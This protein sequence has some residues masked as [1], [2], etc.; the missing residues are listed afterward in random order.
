MTARGA[1]ALGALG[2]IAAITVAWWSLALWPLAALPGWL[3]R[4][5][6]VCFGA[7]PGGLPNAGGWILLVGEPLGLV[8]VLAAVW[9]GALREGLAAAFARPLG[10]AVLAGAALAL[11]LG[12]GATARLVAQVR[13]EPFEIRSAGDVSETLAAGRVN[14]AAPE[15]RLL[16]QYG[17]S[18]ALEQF[19]GRP[20]VVTFGYAHCETVC[21]LTVRA[22]R[23]AVSRSEHGAVLLLVTLDPWRDTPSRLGPI[24]RAWELGDRMHLLSGAVDDVERTLSRWRVPR[25]RNGATGDL[26]HPALVYVIGPTGRIAYALGPDPDAITAAVAGLLS[27]PST[28]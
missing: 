23:D 18:V 19:R 24:A 22:A 17:D 5:R 26:T 20:V 27:A 15:L 1:L 3:E 9:G 16:D 11:V 8:A 10:R 13:G 25:V 2:T 14:D 12:L 21:P 6:E 7:A 28:W 4:T